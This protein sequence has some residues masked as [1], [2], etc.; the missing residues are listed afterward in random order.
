VQRKKT[1]P[2]YI[3]YTGVFHEKIATNFKKQQKATRFLIFQSN[4]KNQENTKKSMHVKKNER[5]MILKKNKS[6]I[7]LI[8]I[9]I[10]K[11]RKRINPF[12]NPLS[13][14]KIEK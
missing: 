13:C 11:H 10:K 7:K 5:D 4:I 9:N 6:D 2:R 14:K 12:E 3:L 1:T 8:I